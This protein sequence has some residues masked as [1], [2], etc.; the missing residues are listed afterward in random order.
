[1]RKPV[2]GPLSR[3]GGFTLIELLVVIAI[4]AILAAMLLP[5]L[6]KAKSRAQ[7]IGCLNDLKQ[8]AVGTLMYASDNEGDFCGSTWNPLYDKTKIKSPWQKN[9]HGVDDDLNW[10]YPY[11]KTLK[12]YI[13]P[14]TQNTVGTNTLSLVVDGQ[15]RTYLKDLAYNA[16]TPK[17]AG[18]SYEV[19]GTLGDL[20][21][22]R[23][24]TVSAFTLTKIPGMEGVRPGPSQ[25]YMLVDA[26]DLGAG[27]QRDPNDHENYPDKMDNH[28]DRGA[29]MSFLD[30]HAQFIRQQQWL[31]TW[32]IGANT[33]RLRPED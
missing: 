32:N 23:E 12:T 2:N 11:V 13:C 9:R 30:G 31:R 4:I 14:S 17:T 16:D 21:K 3:R 10:M 1:M 20:G 5:A 25:I 8:M 15:P 29:T 18:N 24:S 33:Y 28:G 26:D 22:K 27:S 7:E 6:S 19:Y